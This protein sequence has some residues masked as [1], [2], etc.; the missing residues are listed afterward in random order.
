MDTFARSKDSIQVLGGR[1]TQG[2]QPP[3]C[4][5]PARLTLAFSLSMLRSPGG[6]VWDAEVCDQCGGNSVRDGR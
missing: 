1:W 6:A 5:S 2:R 4:L 3:G